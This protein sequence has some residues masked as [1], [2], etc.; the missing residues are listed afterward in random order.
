MKV[1][2]EHPKNEKGPVYMAD[3]AA[4]LAVPMYDVSNVKMLWHAD[5]YDGPLS[6]LCELNRI[7]VWFEF[8]DEINVQVPLT[9][10][11]IPDPDGDV[12]HRRVRRFM[13]V[14]LR[15]DQL[16]AVEKEHELFRTL[17][18]T[19]TDYGDGRKRDIG[20]VHTK[21]SQ[22]QFYSRLKDQV[23]TLDISD[24]PVIGWFEE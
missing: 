13:L 19:H 17:V 11:G 14:D 20:A 3:V 5:Y 12:E 15:P 24:R 23:Y 8:F 10:L 9:D 18:G 7:K 1:I 22:H 21:A 2:T 4:V 6:G 16:A